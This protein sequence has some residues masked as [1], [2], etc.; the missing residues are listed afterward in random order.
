M[1]SKAACYCFYHIQ[2]EQGESASKPNA[3][4]LKLAAGVK[5]CLRDIQKAFP[6]NGTGSFYFRFRVKAGDGFAYLDLPSQAA[7][8]PLLGGNVH[9]KVLR[10]SERS[11]G[12]EQNLLHRWQFSQTH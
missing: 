4:P 10:M 12:C 5:P 7:Q 9:A 6:L 2:G 1:P 8:I 3:F 11:L